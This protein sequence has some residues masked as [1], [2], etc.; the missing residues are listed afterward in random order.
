[1]QHGKPHRMIGHDDQPDARE[2]Q[3][4]LPA[5][6]CENFFHRLRRARKAPFSGAPPF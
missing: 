4:V 2:G 5:E 6:V 3:A 1:M